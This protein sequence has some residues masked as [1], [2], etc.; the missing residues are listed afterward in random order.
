MDASPPP[1]ST[2][3]V[4]LRQQSATLPALLASSLPVR[5]EK[6][7]ANAVRSMVDVIT[8]RS[9]IPRICTSRAPLSYA[10]FAQ[11][12]RLLDVLH[13]LQTRRH[14]EEALEREREH[15]PFAPQVDA[16]VFYYDNVIAQ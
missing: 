7:V 16:A 12:L 1:L 15:E 10:L 2:P 11:A 14:A 9:T 8:D 5:S 3:S 4:A 6:R 13:D